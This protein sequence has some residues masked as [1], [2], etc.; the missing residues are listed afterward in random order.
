MIKSKDV[1]LNEIFKGTG[2]CTE[3]WRIRYEKLNLLKPKLV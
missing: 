1:I 2:C 3:I